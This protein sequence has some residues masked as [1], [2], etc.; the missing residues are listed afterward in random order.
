MPAVWLRRKGRR[1]GS[2]GSIL[3]TSS[4]LELL[5]VI[6]CMSKK[7][8]INIDLHHNDHL[9]IAQR[10]GVVLYIYCP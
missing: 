5:R 9:I 4:A 6:S 3:D 10:P 2:K 8:F 1:R 7:V